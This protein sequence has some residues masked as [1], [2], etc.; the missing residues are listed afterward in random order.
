M[1]RNHLTVNIGISLHTPL[2]NDS[3]TKRIT[4]RGA[5]RYVSIECSSSHYIRK[6]STIPSI[7]IPS[8]TG[9]PNSHTFPS[10][11]VFLH[12]NLASLTYSI[13]PHL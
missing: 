9:S 5:F 4:S 6:T 12:V 11:I 1:S 2:F 3:D 7:Q 10:A 8:R 13:Q